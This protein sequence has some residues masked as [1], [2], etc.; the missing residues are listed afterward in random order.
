LSQTDLVDSGRNGQG[1]I[2]IPDP[3]VPPRAKR[4]HFS[5]ESKL[6]I[7]A[8]VEACTWPGERGALLRREGLYNS[9]LHEWQRQRE[10][11]ALAGL[12][13]KKRGRE[14]NP[15]ASELARL[16][17][18]NERLQKKLKRAKTII[19]FQKNLSTYLGSRWTARSW[20]SRTNEHGRSALV[21]IVE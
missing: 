19:E 9:H 14:P 8:E 16:H 18:E 15:E 2:T 20:T 7:L 1:T 5:P 4:R 6:R 21:K 17:R 11:G 12:T 13:P 3:E 10:Q